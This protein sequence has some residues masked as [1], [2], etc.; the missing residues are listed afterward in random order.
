MMRKINDNYKMAKKEKEKARTKEESVTVKEEPVKEEAGKKSIKNSP[1]QTSKGTKQPE[2]KP[3]DAVKKDTRRS[4]IDKNAKAPAVV[5]KT[6]KT[7][8]A[9]GKKQKSE[10]E[11][12]EAGFNDLLKSKRKASRLSVSGSDDTEKSVKRKK[13]AGSGNKSISSNN[14]TNDETDDDKEGPD[15]ATSRSVSV[16]RNNETDLE[17]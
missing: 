9:S 12:N 4:S 10:D 11:S 6:E 2:N 15:S 13:T 16:D 5:I 14:E 17:K 7:T 1:V 8:P 3:K